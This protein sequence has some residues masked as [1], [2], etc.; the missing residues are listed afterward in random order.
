VQR[1][2][3]AGVAF[4]PDGGSFLTTAADGT[5][6]RWPMP[7]PLEG[8]LDRITLRLQ[9]RTGNQMDGGQGLARLDPQTWQ[10]RRR[11]LVALEGNAEGA[12]RSSVREVAYHD[13]RARDAEQDG[14][15]F[16][17]LW[18]LDR[19]VALRPDDWLLYARR[20][21]AYSIAG[22]LDS[23]DAEYKLAAQHASTGTLVD[24]YRHRVV[25]CEGAGQDATARWYQERVIAAEPIT[26]EVEVLLQGNKAGMK[27]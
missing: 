15:T 23:A 14:A 1:G 7:R 18:H 21:R 22:Q 13:A 9:L 24:W 2:E 27:Q 26:H 19:L 6:R 3:I 17:A 11:Q 4:L 8:D 12:F 25:D 20:G 16:T 5:T 10:A